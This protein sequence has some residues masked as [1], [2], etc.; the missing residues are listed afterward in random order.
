[1]E[2]MVIKKHELIIYPILLWIATV[3]CFTIGYVVAGIVNFIG[4]ILMSLVAYYIPK[5]CKVE[6]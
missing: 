2:K 1:M 6:V 4:T 5:K 3:I